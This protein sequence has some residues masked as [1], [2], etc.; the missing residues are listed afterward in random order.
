MHS[1]LTRCLHFRG[2]LRRDSTVYLGLASYL[3]DAVGKPLFEDEFQD[4]SYFLVDGFVV[5]L[6]GAKVSQLV[7]SGH[8]KYSMTWM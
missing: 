7:T 3:T 2:I 4:W 5:S 1:V 8:F 6:T